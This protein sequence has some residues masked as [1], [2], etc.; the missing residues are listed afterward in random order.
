MSSISVDYL[1]G[2]P[3]TYSSWRLTVQNWVISETRR[4]RFCLGRD[5]GQKNPIAW[6]AIG[7]APEERLRRPSFRAESSNTAVS[8]HHGTALLGTLIRTVVI[9]ACLSMVPKGNVGDRLSTVA[10]FPRLVVARHGI[11]GEQ[12]HEQC[13]NANLD[14]RAMYRAAAL[15]GQDEISSPFSCLAEPRI[16]CSS[17]DPNRRAMSYS[18]YGCG[19]DALPSDT[20]PPAPQK[21]AAVLPYSTEGLPVAKPS[22]PRL[23][24][25]SPRRSHALRRSRA[26]VPVRPSS[27]APTEAGRMGRLSNRSASDGAPRPLHAPDDSRRA[28]TP[29]RRRTQSCTPGHR[30]S[31]H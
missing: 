24:L 17:C 25:T 30:R 14:H 7:D 1:C 16:I 29:I 15:P 19:V 22:L 8:R 20:A 9:G 10:G 4:W 28:L 23:S 12:E 21:K 27:S 6:K 26:R 3:P 13:G 5:P 11:H 18:P 2:R 31:L